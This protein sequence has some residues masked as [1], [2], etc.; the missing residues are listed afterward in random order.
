MCTNMYND[1][2]IC[3]TEVD[4]GGNLKAWDYCDPCCPGKLIKNTLYL[5]D[6]P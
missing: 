4:S 1:D 5:C 3:A 2:Y 6:I